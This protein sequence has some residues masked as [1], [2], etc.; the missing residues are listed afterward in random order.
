MSP[1][2]SKRIV[3][4]AP[5]RLSHALDETAQLLGLSKIATL[6]LALAILTQITRELAH[7]GRLILRDPD[8]TD[9]ELWL[10]YL[11]HHPTRPD[12]RGRTH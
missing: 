3:F 4:E 9:R 6:R 8:G 2:P 5:A 1:E 12:H 11:I 7:G 10:P